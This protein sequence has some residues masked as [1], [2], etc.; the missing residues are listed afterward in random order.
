MHLIATI[1][2]A[3]VELQWGRTLPGGGERRTRQLRGALAA[4]FRG[5]DLFHQHDL[6]TGKTLYRYPRVQYR[7]RDGQG[8]VIGWGEA[9]NRLMALPWLDLNL[10]LGEDAVVVSDAVLTLNPGQFGVA[11]RLGY[12]RLASPVLLFNQDNYRRYQA[13]DE[14]AQRVERDRLLVSNLLIAMR[15]LGVT[16]P[17]RL[18]A[19]FVQMRTSP[20]HYKGGTLLG[21]TGELATNAVLPDGFAIGHAVSH[22]FGWLTL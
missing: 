4:A 22:G 2:Y 3:Q 6:V 11:E 5:D 9:A 21:L 12:Y 7:W 8:L 19:T 17:E 13:L 10:Q 14:A 16:F 15:G 20:C 18:H 1:L